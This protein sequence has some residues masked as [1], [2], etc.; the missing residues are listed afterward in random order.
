MFEV[1]RLQIKDGI[2]SLQDFLAATQKHYQSDLKAVDFMGAPED[3]R[4]E[5]N[6]WVEEKT[7]SEN[8]TIN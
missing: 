5:I 8:S 3:C 7:E 6:G 1:N 2:H 4:Q